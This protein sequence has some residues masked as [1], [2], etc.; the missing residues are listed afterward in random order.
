MAQAA[1]GPK[2]ITMRVLLIEDDVTTAAKIE[3][4]L[5]AENFVCDIADLGGKGVERGKL[6]DYDIIILD[7][8]LPDFDGYQVLKRLRAARVHTPG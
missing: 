7:L 8:M 1:A 4:I 5:Q 3:L 2:G 6:Y